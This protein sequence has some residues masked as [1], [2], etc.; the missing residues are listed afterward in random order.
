MEKVRITID[1]EYEKLN[2]VKKQCD[3]EGISRNKFFD[4]A[5]DAYK[6][7]LEQEGQ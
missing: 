2:W 5:I 4:L 3:K 6:E 7:K 1:V